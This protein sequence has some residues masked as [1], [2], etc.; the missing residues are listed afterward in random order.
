MVYSHT[1]G[2]LLG[3]P[4]LLWVATIS[5]EILGKT[6]PMAGDYLLFR[7]YRCCHLWFDS[8][9]ALAC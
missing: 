3:V 9:S 2:L 1:Y 8:G 5:R 4:H 7:Q 6:N